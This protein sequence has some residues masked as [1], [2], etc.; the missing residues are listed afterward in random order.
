MHIRD[1]APPHCHTATFIPSSCSLLIFSLRPLLLPSSC[2]KCKDTH[3][4]FPFSSFENPQR[5]PF[6]N[7]FPIPSD[8]SW[9]VDTSASRIWSD[10]SSSALHPAKSIWCLCLRWISDIVPLIESPYATISMK[11]D[12]L[13]GNRRLLLRLSIRLDH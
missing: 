12:T 6:R 13:L 11:S 10:L 4:K 9:L 7:N 3:S 2:A 5:T 8:L 1:S